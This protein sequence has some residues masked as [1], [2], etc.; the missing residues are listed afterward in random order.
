MAGCP[1]LIAV[2]LF[3]DASLLHKLG[4]VVPLLIL[5]IAGAGRTPGLL[6]DRAEPNEGIRR[7]RKR[8]LPLTLAGGSV[9]FAAS[10]PFYGTLAQALVFAVAMAV[11]VALLAGYPVVQHYLLR[12]LLA[13]RGLMPRHIDLFLEEAT[14]MLFLEHTGSG[15]AFI[16]PLLKTYFANLDPTSRRQFVAVDSYLGGSG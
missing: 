4:Y 11:M 12:A 15:Y 2:F 16:H 9:A 5:M 7:T 1:I 14:D 3:R 13:Y 8:L 10:V 6:N